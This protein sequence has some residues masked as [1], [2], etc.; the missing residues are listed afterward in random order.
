MSI[1][2][3]DQAK[4]LGRAYPVGCYYFSNKNNSPASWVGGTWTPITNTFLYSSSS[5]G[6]AGSNSKQIY[7]FLPSHSHGN[8]G[9]HTHTLSTHNHGGSGSIN[10][11]HFISSSHSLTS[12]DTSH[13][14]SN[15]NGY[16]GP[17]SVQGTYQTGTSSKILFIGGYSKQY[18]GELGYPQSISCSSAS[19]TTGGP[20]LSN[21]DYQ[22]VN[23][24][25]KT[26]YTSSVGTDGYVTLYDA[27]SYLPTLDCYCWRRDG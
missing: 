15:C 10:H 24:S 12:N 7:N 22:Y 4:L 3:K 20:S 25:G 19:A 5:T 11:S 14:H 18:S 21:P 1:N 6:S 9:N 2:A 13:N 16:T 17:P 23:L 26:V 27:S 8:I